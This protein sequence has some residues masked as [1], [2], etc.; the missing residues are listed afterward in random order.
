MKEAKVG[1][2]TCGCRRCKFGQNNYEKKLRNRAR[3]KK[4][5]AQL[6]HIKSMR[7]IDDDNELRVK[8]FSQ[9]TFD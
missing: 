1:I 9:Y 6:R 3:R 5:S 2:G 8:V 7:N 4:I